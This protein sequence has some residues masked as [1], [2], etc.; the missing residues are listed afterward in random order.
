[1]TSVPIINT[2]L[3]RTLK[4]GLT[5]GSRLRCTV[6]LFVA[7]ARPQDVVL[8]LPLPS[9]TCLHS[10]LHPHGRAGA[11]ASAVTVEAKAR[12]ERDRTSW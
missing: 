8:L 12:R 9:F 2:G 7:L 4:S 10:C 1:M 6:L 11:G 3:L 5:H